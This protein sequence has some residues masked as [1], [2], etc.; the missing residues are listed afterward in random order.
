MVNIKEKLSNEMVALQSQIQ[1][2]KVLKETF[3]ADLDRLKENTLLKQITESMNGTWNAKQMNAA[4]D[5]KIEDI[6]AEREKWK[7]LKVCI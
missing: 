7:Q 1:A 6:N 4:M 3:N 5:K 2:A